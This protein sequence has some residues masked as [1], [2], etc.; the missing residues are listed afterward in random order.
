MRSLVRERR[1]GGV[2]KSSLRLVTRMATLELSEK[3][4]RNIE[5]SRQQIREGKFVTLQEL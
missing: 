1:A 2:S 3:I 5:K 4:Q